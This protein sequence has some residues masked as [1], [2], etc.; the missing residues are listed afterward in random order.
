MEIV[1]IVHKIMRRK[2]PRAMIDGT[3]VHAWKCENPTI[4]SSPDL[5]GKCLEHM[6][7]CGE[8]GKYLG[9]SSAT[10]VPCGGYVHALKSETRSNDDRVISA[11]F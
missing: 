2:Q 11:S 7:K 1:E 10:T 5:F 3:M 8:G 4:S 9:I 6:K